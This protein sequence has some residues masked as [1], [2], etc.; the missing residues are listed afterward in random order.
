[1]LLSASG[2]LVLAGCLCG[3]TLWGNYPK[4]GLTML[5][6]A[7]VTG[8]ASFLRHDG[9]AE[10]VTPRDPRAR[11][12]RRVL[13]VAMVVHVGVALYQCRTRPA[14]DIDC[15]TFQRDA[16]ARL[17]R[18]VDPYGKTQTNILNEDMTR[19]FY[20]PGMVVNGQ[21]QVG[22]QYPP[23]TL[24]WVSP[25]YL[26]GDVRYSYILATLLTAGLSFALWE[27]SSGFWLALL[28]LLD[29]LTYYIENRC[30]TESLVLLT[31]T[32]TVYAAVKKRWWLPVALGLF[33]ASKQYNFLAVPFV[34]F[35]LT[36]FAWR[37]YWRLMAGAVGIAL[38]T[39]L[40][41]A[42]AD[43]HGL[44]RDLVLFH[45]RQPFRMDAQSFAV[46]YPWL[47]KVCPWLTLGFVVWAVWK[48]QRR[49]AVFAAG[50]GVAL[51]IFVCMNKQAFD[52]Y[53]FLIGQTILLGAATLR[54]RLW[55]TMEAPWPRV[56]GG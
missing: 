17:L 45:L 35:L 26:L 28:L 15:Y 40:P 25:G 48:A 11:V 8:V 29:P 20:G 3:S 10:P 27:G 21:V 55:G 19:R 31:M 53:Y 16:E 30:W 33:L 9:G 6:L 1:M 7:V 39:L 34:G 37:R 22:F 43:W 49:V 5:A 44:V 38:L 4:V 51:L 12:F 32:L 24:L 54:G 47:L 46:P 42:I 23:V 13:V 36:P 2:V 50:Y 56:V 14:T 41:F 52:N 18:G